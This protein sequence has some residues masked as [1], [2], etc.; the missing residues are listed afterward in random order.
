MKTIYT[1]NYTD[2]VE[3]HPISPEFTTESEA[4]SFFE[5][6]KEKLATT[7]PADTTGWQDHDRAWSQVYQLEL[8]K[9]TF[10]EDGDVEDIEALETTEYYYE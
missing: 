4:R 3:S 5:Q 9:T 8:T 10:D 1:V 6:K 2:N 7:T